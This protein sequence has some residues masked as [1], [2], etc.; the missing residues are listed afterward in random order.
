MDIKA[1][2]DAGS[3]GLLIYIVFIVGQKV[4]R[5]MDTNERLMSQLIEIIGRE[6]KERSELRN[7][8]DML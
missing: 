3:L 7:N 5:M 1:I 8:D 2:I 4:D 6:A